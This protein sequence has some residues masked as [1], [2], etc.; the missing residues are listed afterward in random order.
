MKTRH[1]L[2][3]LVLF[4]CAFACLHAQPYAGIVNGDTIRLEEMARE[5]GRRTEFA[6]LGR[7]MSQPDIIEATWNDLVT[8]TLVFQE[9]RKRQIDVTMGD[10]DSLLLNRTPDYVRRGIVDEKGRF[11]PS[12]LR[13]MLFSPDSLVRAHSD[14]IPAEARQQQIDDIRASMKDLRDR[15]RMTMLDVRLREA[16]AKEIPVDSARLRASF[17][18]AASRCSADVIFLPCLPNTKEPTEAELQRWYDQHKAQYRTEHELR[19]LVFMAFKVEASRA[20]SAMI[21]RNVTDFVQDCMRKPA[22]RLRD[23]LFQSVARTTSSGNAVVDPDSADHA[24]FYNVCRGKKRGDI[25]G[26]IKLKDGLHVL[27]IDSVLKGP[28][29][30]R[31]RYAVTALN[32][33]IDATKPTLD[34]ILQNVEATIE[35]YEAGKE[36]GEVAQAAHKQIEVTPYFGIDERLFGSYAIVDAA[37]RTQVAAACD[38]VDTPERGVLVAIVVDSV[39][40]GPMPFDAAIEKVR[41]DLIHDRTCLGRSRE[42]RELKDMCALTPEGLFVI[43]EHPKDAKIYRDVSIDRGGMIGDEVM[44][45]LAAKGIYDQGVRGIIGPVYGDNGWYV[46]NI[47]DIVKANPDEFGM[48]MQLNGAALVESQHAE[49]YDR[50]L[51]GVRSRSTID[52]KRWVYFRY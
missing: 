7:P 51:A 17:E 47:R 32:T 16:L 21:I 14:D 48:F 3:P 25:V 34:S 26:P 41:K 42:A 50:W 35:S 33:A 5:V 1:I 9:C 40:P 43:A 13:A 36:L 38:P 52:D 22:G 23:S 20:D 39:A 44:D 46:V 30:T 37:F 12:L 11:D 6:K 15:V 29:R 18:N 8:R 19:R 24:P 2:L 10:V 49:A 28:S 27:R 45:T 4:A 31:P